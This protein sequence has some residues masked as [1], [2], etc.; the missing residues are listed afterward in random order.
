[1]QSIFFITA[2]EIINLIDNKNASE[3]IATLRSRLPNFFESDHSTRKAKKAINEEF[4][5]LEP[6]ATPTGISISPSILRECL[7]YLYHWLGLEEWWR[8]FGDAS[9]FGKDQSCIFGITNVNNSQV[10]NGIQW[11][12]PKEVW[13]THFSLNGDSRP[14][15]EANIGANGGRLNNFVREMT[16]LR[17]KVLLSGDSKFCDALFGTNLCA[18]SKTGWNIYSEES[19]L[20]KGDFDAATGRRSA[21]NKTTMNRE[22]PDKLLDIPLEH[23]GV[24]PNHAVSRITEKLLKLTVRSIHQVT[25]LVPGKEGVRQRNMALKHLARN[26]SSRNIHR[27]KS[28]VF[29]I[30]FDDN[31]QLKDFTLNTT[32]A[33]VILAS[34]EAFGPDVQYKPIL[35]NVFPD[36]PHVTPVPDDLARML[37][38]GGQGYSTG[39]LISIL[40]GLMWKMHK[41]FSMERV[42][43]KEGKIPGSKIEEDY[44]FGLTDEQIEAY[45]KHADMFHRLFCF[46]Y[47]A[48]ELTP[49]MMKLI[50]VVPML[51]RSLPFRSPMRISTE[52][53][54]HRH[55]MNMV[56]FYQHT[57]RWGGRNKPNVI[58]QLFEWQW[59][60]LRYR[61]QSGPQ[62]IWG[63]FQTFVKERLAKVHAQIDDQE[64]VEECLFP[65]AAHGL[66]FSGQTFIPI[67]KMKQSP[68]EIEETVTSLGGRVWKKD[69]PDEK[70]QLNWTVITTQNECDRPEGGVNAK[71]ADAFRRGWCIVSDIYLQ[72]CF[73]MK[74][75]VGKENF[76]LNLEKLNN[77]P[78]QFIQALKP[79]TRNNRQTSDG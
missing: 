5:I 68:A 40:H 28:G 38:I 33:E 26:I 75:D 73:K 72:E 32:A 11:H 61:I 35:D 4:K 1:M 8:L 18:T 7:M 64:E 23:V 14:C 30:Q 51:M 45:V 19:V 74:F 57:N 49:Y 65:N 52:A 22:H 47:G 41:I 36:R 66:P 53:G 39:Q 42:K 25:S 16:S 20:S 79:T 37:A 21:L 27:G 31:D 15:L 24:D 10:L 3:I 77:A 60:Q 62:E 59:R 58:T 76:A 13:I 44:E 29:T 69:L 71:L 78:V 2:E 12:S 63:A 48:C 54:E 34:P 6:R 55:Y 56:Y 70:L 17:N 67:G 43:L 46:L 9:K 50:D